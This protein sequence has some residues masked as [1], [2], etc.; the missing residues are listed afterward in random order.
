MRKGLNKIIA[1]FTA[2]LSF[3]V[4][5]PL[6]HGQVDIVPGTG[7]VGFLGVIEGNIILIISLLF[8]VAT[9]VFLWGI[10]TYLTAAGDENKLST[11][12]TYIL[13]GIV[14]LF[15]MLVVWG[16]VELL[17]TTF[18]VGGVS[19]NSEKGIPLLPL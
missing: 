10:V 19:G 12:K 18:N 5:S 15:V 14:A 11:G 4:S 1:T 16:L 2:L 9:A 17:I 7:V 6:A 3:L 13:W 8:V